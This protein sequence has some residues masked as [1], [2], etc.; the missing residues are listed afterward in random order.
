MQKQVS[1]AKV[2]QGAI[3]LPG[4]KSISHRYAMISAIADGPT[5]VKRFPA[6][7]DNQSTLRCME[8]LG[9]EVERLPDEVV[10]HGKGLDGL[11]APAADLDC[12]NSGST[13][14]ML[15]G[16]LAAQPFQST[17]FG[18]ESL[19]RRPMDRIMKPLSEMGAS[20]TARDGRFPPLQVHGNKL[21]A[22]HYAP[23]MASAQVKSCVLLAGLFCED[24]TVVFEPIRTRDHTEIALR[25][26]GADITTV[27]DEITLKGRPNLTGNRELTVPGDIS[28]A[29]FF[30][31]AA[32]LLPG[33][34]LSIYGVGLNP[35]RSALLDFLAQIG[36]QPKILDI[37]Q[38]GGELVGDLQIKYAPV[39]G[40]VLEG[41]MTAAL[42]DEIPVLSVLGAVSEEGL[43]VKDAKELRVKETDR[44]ATVAEN[45]RRMG[46]Q[47][48]VEETGF[49]VPGKQKFK[50]A[51]LDSFHDHRIA[52]A[53]A[54][55]S[56]AAEGG[57]SMIDNADAASVSFPEFYSTLE[58][59]SAA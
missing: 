26:F 33:S 27:R 9:I 18:D 8:Q 29:A 15:S 4:D 2:L 45:M 57:P 28:S 56:L 32:L 39:K 6:G 22:I 43:T 46:I 38:S 40:G 50:A 25:E 48:E 49:H 34:Q 5:R 51:Q 14:R 36:A 7:G 19:T 1:P 35:T 10:I 55:A 3:V 47:I 53:F 42:I 23:P 41:A 59:I 12:G 30:L 24:D 44:I 31:V 37:G 16:I 13:M 20:F 52:M 17:M 58:Q 21:H 11:R 54:I